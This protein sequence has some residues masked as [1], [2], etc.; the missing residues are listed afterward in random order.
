MVDSTENVN[1]KG[2]RLGTERLI[3]M[4]L[5]IVRLDKRKFPLSCL[6]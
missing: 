2:E 3:L 1:R 6:A 4:T 5:V